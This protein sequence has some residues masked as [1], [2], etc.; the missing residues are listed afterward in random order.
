MKNQ[1]KKDSTKR[2]QLKKA[3]NRSQFVVYDLD[4]HNDLITAM[5]STDEILITARY[6]KQHLSL[7]GKLTGID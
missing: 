4:G 6:V 2:K 1:L 7:I 3:W 5:D